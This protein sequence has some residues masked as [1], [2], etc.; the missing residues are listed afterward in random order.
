MTQ[1]RLFAS[2][3]AVVNLIAITV[4]AADP[5]AISLDPGKFELRGGRAQQQLVVSG[6]FSADD[7]RDLTNAGVQFASS[8]PAVVKI[9][10]TLAKPVAD[11]TAQITATLGGSQ[12]HDGSDRQRDGDAVASQ[13]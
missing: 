1:P 7:I 6:T 2:T 9:E 4:F 3:F 10:G 8:N 5:G 12:G 11:G 13:L